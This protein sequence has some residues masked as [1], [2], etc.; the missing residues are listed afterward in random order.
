MYVIG[1]VRSRVEV[2][3]DNSEGMAESIFLAQMFLQLALLPLLG[4]NIRSS[5]HTLL[6]AEILSGKNVRAWV[7]MD[8][9]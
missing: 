3:V 1:F 2:Y 8:F 9:T 4:L 6:I 5:G 7:S